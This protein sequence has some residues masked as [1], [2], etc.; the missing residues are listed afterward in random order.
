MSSSRFVDV[1]T[2]RAG[3][4]SL[5]LPDLGTFAPGTGPAVAAE[6]TVCLGAMEG[7][8]FALNADGTPQWQ[9]Q[10]P[11]G[12]R[13]IAS[14]AIT[15]DGH[16]VYV[17]GVQLDENAAPG[18]VA[19]L[20]PRLN[21]LIR[22]N[23]A[24]ASW[25]FPE[26]LDRV[27]NVG[28]PAIWENIP[29]QIGH[30]IL[31]S[32]L[33]RD[34]FGN[35][36]LWLLAF[37]QTGT[38]LAEHLV[39][40][41]TPGDV[42]GSGSVWAAIWNSF[43][44]RPGR[45]VPFHPPP[46]PYPSVSLSSAPTPTIAVCDRGVAKVHGF[47]LQFGSNCPLGGACFKELFAPTSHAPRTLWSSAAFLMDGRAIVGTDEG[48]IF[49]GGASTPPPPAPGGLEKVLGTPTIAAGARPVIVD[50][51]GRLVTM[52]QAG[53]VST[54]VQLPGYTMASAAASRTHIF[55]ATTE[56]LHTLDAAGSTIVG[57]F[58]WT[59]GGIW[60]PAVGPQGHV[61]AMAANTLF[62]FPRPA[63]PGG[64]TNDWGFDPDRPVNG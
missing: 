10:L 35:A 11:L 44:F 20:A 50:L 49:S 52:H 13:I 47:T 41:W 57:T 21:R 15:R 5:S 62:V 1:A 34:R 46:A 42:V 26:H 59:D 4:G 28:A 43:Q 51:N 29:G 37:A 19:T 60:N 3:S 18:A 23:G 31:V 6:G 8:V 22:P 36:E 45:W 9:A 55:V 53:G 16:Y 17:V 54:R 58:P 27:T 12:Q 39:S 38:L 7:K 48:V 56:G 14:P 61:Y 32:A 2:A 30:V 33:Y 63:T 64:A 25:D 24:S 40:S